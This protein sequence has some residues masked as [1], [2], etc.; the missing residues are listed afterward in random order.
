M[1]T[2][3]GEYEL[4]T[5]Q[6]QHRVASILDEPALSPSDIA[7]ALFLR[8]DI[9]LLSLLGLNYMAKTEADTLQEILAAYEVAD[10]PLAKE[11]KGRN[12][13]YYEPLTSDDASLLPNERAFGVE[14]AV[15]HNP[16]LIP[17]NKGGDVLRPLYALKPQLPDAILPVIGKL[18]DYLA[19]ELWHRADTGESLFGDAEHVVL[20]QS[21][22][23]PGIFY[24]LGV[25]TMTGGIQIGTASLGAMPRSVVLSPLIMPNQGRYP[26]ASLYPLAPYS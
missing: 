11:T 9:G 2:V 12:L 8:Q 1:E 26:G 7:S 25:N 22:P 13:F 10:I 3:K 6:F 24:T 5:R 21:S 20:T 15:R 17:I 18:S 23:E 16:T 4:A 19:I 14:I